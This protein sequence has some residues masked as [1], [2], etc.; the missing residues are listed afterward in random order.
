MDVILVV[1]EVFVETII[2]DVVKRCKV[3]ENIST[4]Y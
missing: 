1:L 2:S 3:A 4:L